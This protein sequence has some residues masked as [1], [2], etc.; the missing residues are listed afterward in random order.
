MPQKC[1][2][3][4]LATLLR[5]HPEASIVKDKEPHFFSIKPDTNSAL[6]EYLLMY[7]H[8]SN[9]IV[10]GDA[11]TSYSR[12]QKNHKMIKRI[13]NFTPE[14]KIIFMIRHPLERIESAYAD[15]ILMPNINHRQS[16][17]ESIRQI[18]MML[19]SSRYW[20][21]FDAY[22]QVFPEKNIKVIWFVEFFQ[23]QP[24]MF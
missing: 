6:E 14:A 15:R 3:T 21:V 1:A 7:S 11:S 12:I 13:Y 9:E 24:K 19:D 22:R 23:N 17:S 5:A 2:T 4:T 18:P 10:I 16:L 20:E 8:C